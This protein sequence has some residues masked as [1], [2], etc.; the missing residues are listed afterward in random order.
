MPKLQYYYVARNHSYQIKQ[1]H[2]VTAIPGFHSQHIKYQ[3][4]PNS[5]TISS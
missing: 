4:S 1:A 3:T 2:S 5:S